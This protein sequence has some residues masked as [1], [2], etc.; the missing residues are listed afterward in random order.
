MYYF[1]HC[2]IVWISLR[3]KKD[4]HYSLCFLHIKEHLMVSIFGKLSQVRALGHGLSSLGLGLV[5]SLIFGHY[6]LSKFICLTLRCVVLWG[7]EMQMSREMC[8]YGWRNVSAKKKIWLEKCWKCRDSFKKTKQWYF[9]QYMTLFF[10]FSFF[11]IK[12]IL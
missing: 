1:Q 10:S 7:Q 2:P 9:G 3:V 5:L 11:F 8:Q 12:I 4:I 6:F